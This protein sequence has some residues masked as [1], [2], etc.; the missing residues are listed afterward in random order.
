MSVEAASK[1]QAAPEIRALEAEAC[2]SRV[3]NV[4]TV[5]VEDWYHLKIDAIDTWGSHE[6]RVHVGVD[7]LLEMMEHQGVRGTF[8]VLA[9]VAETTPEV[10]RRIARA[11]HEVASHG[12]NHQLVYRQTE[13]Q[14]EADL[15]RSLGLLGDLV[16]EPIRGYRASSFSVSRKTPW[17]WDVLSRNGITF[18]SSTFP[19][20]NAFY[21]GLEV[22]PY[23]HRRP[24]GD[25]VEVP[26]SPV[27]LAGIPVPFS[28]GFYFRLHSL[29]F[30]EWAR[31]R[32]NEKGRPVV[33]YVHPWEYDPDQPRMDLPPHWRFFRYH[34][35]G[36]MGKV[37]DRALASSR[38]E[39]MGEL[40]AGI[41]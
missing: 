40:A 33:Y 20:L 26:I 9:Y 28:G 14:F 12:Y 18:D 31:R 22:P 29:G 8:F 24:G 5:D 4:F 3:R 25:I 15:K 13:A 11:G 37:T 10:V 34:R 2:G 23:P 32:L 35:L 30:L 16:G 17:F 41:A 21:G 27:S 1:A 38:F 6:R 19:V 36:A 39:T 7:R